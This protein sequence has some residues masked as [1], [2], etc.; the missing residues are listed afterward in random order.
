[1]TIKL[2]ASIL[3]VSMTSA[4]T[5]A[6]L[7]NTLPNPVPPFESISGKRV[8][9]ELKDSSFK[10]PG[11]LVQQ[12]ALW[13]GSKHIGIIETRNYSKNQDMG[14]GIYI[15]NHEVVSF[16]F[17]G[18]I[19]DIGYGYPFKELETQPQKLDFDSRTKTITLTKPY[20]LPGGRTATFKWMLKGFD[21]GRVELSWDCGLGDNADKNIGVAPWLIFN[22]DYRSSDLTFNGELVEFPDVSVISKEYYKDTQIARGSVSKIVYAPE[23]PLKGFSID[24]PDK[25]EYGTVEHR[26]GGGLELKCMTAGS[27]KGSI[28]IDMG[29]SAVSS[30]A[31]HPPVAGIDFWRRDA[32]CVPLSVTR[33]LVRNPSFEQGLRYWSWWHGGAD[34]KPS[35]P[36]VYSISDEGMF[37]GKSLCL[38]PYSGAMPMLSM[39]VAVENGKTY[40]LSY[41]AKAEKPDTGITVG[42]MSAMRGS[43][44]NWQ[45]AGSSSKRLSEGKWERKSFTFVSDTR[46]LSIWIMASRNVLIDG[47]QLEEGKEATEFS[48]PVVEGRIESAFQDNA[49]ESGKPFDAKFVLAGKPGAKGEF[50]L[51]FRDF[52]RT[53]ILKIKKNY[54]LDEKGSASFALPLE[55]ALGKGIYI[56]KAQ[57]RPEGAAAYTDFYRLSILKSLE[58]LHPTK[59]LF[60]NN[61]AS[62]ITRGDDLGKLYMR[63]GWGYTTAYGAQKN[64][65]DFLN[66]Y[67]ISYG[68]CLITYNFDGFGHI[69]DRE[70]IKKFK[71]AVWLTEKISEADARFIEDTV[72]DTVKA[73]NWAKRWALSTE[74]EGESVLTRAR[75]FDEYAKVLQAFHR[76]VKRAVPDAEVYPDGGTS[77]FSDSRGYAE[78]DGYMGSTRGKVKWDAIAVHPYGAIDG[79]CGTGDLDTETGKL[80]ALMKKNGYGQETPIDFDE[81]FNCTYVNIPEWGDTGC[82]DDYNSGLPSYDSGWKE[83]RHACWVARSY[84]MCMKYWPQLRSANIWSGNVV[85]DQEL[86][87]VSYDMIPNILG[88]LFPNPKFKADIRPAGGIRGYAFESGDDC[89]AA[90]WCVMDKVDEGFE[91]GPE[92]NVLFD[93]IKPEA[94]DLMGN[95]R[96]IDV[97][98]GAAT[99]VRLSPAPLFFRVKK[100]DAD[101]LIGALSK[102]EVTGVGSSLRVSFLPKRSGEIEAKLVNKT[103]NVVKGKLLIKD[104]SMPFEI[105]PMATVDKILPVKLSLST[106]KIESWKQTIGVEFPNGKRE[107]VKWDMSCLRVPHVDKPLPLDPDSKD[108]NA[109][110]AIPV[111]NW[112]VKDSLYTTRYGY[113]GDLDAKFQLAWDK[114]NL[115]LR[116]ACV[117]DKFIPLDQAKWTP[118]ALYSNDGCVEVYL[119][120]VASGRGNS[121]KGYDQYD[122]RYDFAPGSGRAESGPGSVYRLQEVFRQLAGGMSMPTREQASKGVKCEFR[123]NGNS[124]S[125]VMILPQMYIEP[126]HLESGWRAGF[127]LY[128]HDKDT[129]EKNNPSSPEKGVSISTKKGEHCNFRPD[130]WPVIVLD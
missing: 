78:M 66:K 9:P 76:G 90:I 117:D 25:R 119:D 23:N 113:P 79:V 33:N 124:Y 8:A 87:P 51:S 69:K 94:I 32:I 127:G 80:V 29:P 37:G 102:A 72:Y 12:P 108:W 11:G 48:A 120:T 28:I 91:Y 39:P 26:T 98:R 105:A 95:K 6:A 77:G 74:S 85:I 45:Q 107:N 128:I 68:P 56:I 35:E 59:A 92:I 97:S 106:G 61:I 84:I 42:I 83:F 64:E 58:N 40:T 123:R 67:R 54:T 62:R 126:L 17:W 38:R 125:Y 34:Y 114:D 27:Q 71:Q 41:Y 60:G 7:D 104:E 36:A 24:F 18:S 16:R 100:E 122:Y 31:A 63:W 110:P 21:E 109:I 46:A 22:G 13:F 86:T 30:A 121:T 1:M 75:N 43:K 111:N 130:L 53:D 44:F 57:F 103:S 129:G 14:I 4:I 81:L 101:K 10:T 15:D 93:G 99:P 2:I 52:Y 47:I 3:A 115:Y 19:K 49:L 70:L 82:N 20:A 88:N 116:V 73:N 118:T 112:L 65:N 5:A 55:G 50:E 89:I 96:E